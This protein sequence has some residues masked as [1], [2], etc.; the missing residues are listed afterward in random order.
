MTGLMFNPLISEIAKNQS[1]QIDVEN[2][3]SFQHVFRSLSTLKNSPAGP[4]AADGCT[5]WQFV[6]IVWSGRGL[7]A[8]LQNH[9][10]TRR[11]FAKPLVLLL[12]SW[13]WPPL[14]SFGKPVIRLKVAGKG[15]GLRQGIAKGSWKF[16]NQYLP[17][18][19]RRGAK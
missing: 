3:H 9:T 16:S 4:S 13:D 2:S 11:V 10:T 1:V 8:P 14:K 12:S 15:R 7:A 18:K 19:C 17:L 6:A 5:L